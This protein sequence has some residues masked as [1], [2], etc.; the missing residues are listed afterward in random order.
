MNYSLS[1]IA[2]DEQGGVFFASQGEEIRYL[3]PGN[4]PSARL[5][6]AITSS[7]SMTPPGTPVTGAFQSSEPVTITARLQSPG[8]APPRDVAITQSGMT[9]G[10]FSWN[11]TLNGAS[12]P[13][14]RYVLE[15]HARDRRGRTGSRI[16][17]I[18]ITP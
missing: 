2:V 7:P 15:L 13:T 14:G 8:A 6:F 5:G 9:H 3:A 11:G 1:S 12:A 4:A 16:L 17:P 10:R 18:V